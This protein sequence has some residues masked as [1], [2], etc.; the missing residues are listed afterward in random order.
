VLP[1]HSFVVLAYGHSEHLED[2]LRSLQAQTAASP[3]LISTSTPFPGLEQLAERFGAH[4]HVHGPNQGIGH[5]WNQGLAAANSE[6]VTLVH[7]DDLYSPDFAEQTV[8]AFARQTDA[9]FAF[10]DSGEVRSDGSRRPLAW[11]HR[12]KE[13]LVAVATWPGSPVKGSTRRR[14]LLGFGNPVICASVTLNR[15]EWPTFR[16]R[17]DLRTNMDWL[18]WLQL[19][20]NHPVL[21]IRRRLVDRRV[22]DGS[23]TAQCI[24]DGARLAEDQLVFR[25]L[26][27]R[28][29]AAMISYIYRLSYSGYNS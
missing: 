8:A 24:S 16:F 26:W 18:A 20:A 27:P 6:L 13:L 2:C 3:I 10:C 5:D 15:R 14:L 17:E 29:A 21:R 25:E 22:H 28:P 12:I 1:T 7:Q 19:S 23:A 9:A 11:N 4:L